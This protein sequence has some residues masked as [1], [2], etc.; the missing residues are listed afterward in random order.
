MKE[1]GW[2][3]IVLI[4]AWIFAIYAAFYRGKEIGRAEAVEKVMMECKD[5]TYTGQP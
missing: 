2:L 3:W 5:G 4:V 1:P